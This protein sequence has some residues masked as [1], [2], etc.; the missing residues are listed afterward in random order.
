VPFPTLIF[1]VF[2]IG[3]AAAM[4]SKDALRMSVRPVL[5]STSFATYLSFLVLVAIPISVYF[6]LFHGDWFLLYLSDVRKIPSA[7][8]LLGFLLE[9][10][11]GA[12]GFILGAALARRRQFVI[13]YW[14]IGACGALGLSVFGVFRNRLWRVGSYTQYHFGFALKSY[15]S[16]AIFVGALLMSAVLAAATAYLVFRLRYGERS[17]R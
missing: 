4:A 6:Y 10:C 2:G 1:L 11:V 15:A 3:I 14:I 8:A 5:L 17:R 7:V 16:S 13:G 9:G 12:A